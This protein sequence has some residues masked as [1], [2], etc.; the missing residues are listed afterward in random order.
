MSHF[1]FDAYT[2]SYHHR[3]DTE[4]ETFKE[5]FLMRTSFSRKID[6]IIRIIKSIGETP[7][8][9]FK[10][11]G[12]RFGI[13]RNK[14]AHQ[15]YPLVREGLMHDMQKKVIEVEQKEW[16]GMYPEAKALFKK[17]LKELDDKFYTEEPRMRKY[18]SWALLEKLD[19]IRKYE[20]MLKKEEK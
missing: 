11:D 3:L 2:A 8:P 6:Y 15:S 12:E 16:E 10:K 20:E 5:C 9:G 17:I 19:I 4:R 1:G 7:Y 18:R 13:I 14:F